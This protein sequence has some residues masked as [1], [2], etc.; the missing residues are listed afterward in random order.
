VANTG[1]VRVPF[2]RAAG[3]VAAA[4]AVAAVTVTVLAGGAAAGSARG[5]SAKTTRFVAGFSAGTPAQVAS[6]AGDGVTADILYGGPPG[7]A[8][9]LGRALARYHMTAI[10]ARL[11]GELFYWECHRTHT[12]APPPKGQPNDYCAKDEKPGVDSP[13]VVLK[14]IGGWLR[15]DAS[16]PLVSGYWVLDDWPYWDG[17]SARGLLREI[18]REIRAVTP[19][20]PAICGF[21]GTVLKPGQ[22]GG[23]DASTA[24]NYSDGGCDMVG[25]YNYANIDTLTHLRVRGQPRPAR[26]ANSWPP[27]TGRS[28]ARRASARSC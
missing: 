24:E 14:T 12:V 1:P 19:G 5:V 20:Y 2:L 16:N 9:P 28:S 13:A 3:T 21:G 23:F 10:D 26:L 27:G 18:R 22:A 25:W 15:Q 6:A 11:S 8:S 17:G 7:P 4:A